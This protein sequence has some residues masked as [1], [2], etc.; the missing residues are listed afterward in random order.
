MAFSNPPVDFA[1]GR[2]EAVLRISYGEKSLAP[3]PLSSQLSGG[4]GTLSVG[5][6][7]GQVHQCPRHGEDRYLVSLAGADQLSKGRL[8]AAPAPPDEYP[9][10]CVDH[11]GGSLAVG[12]ELVV[13]LKAL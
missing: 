4:T 13:T 2:I 3:F 8:G 5:I 6:P 10:R 1:P 7:T 11:P 12:A 9:Y